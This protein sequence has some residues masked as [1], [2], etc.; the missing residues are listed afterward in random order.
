MAFISIDNVKILGIASAV[1]KTVKVNTNDKLINTTGVA[2]R[3]IVDGI[4]TSDLC[5]VSANKLI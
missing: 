4:N 2:Q 1:P 3:R 5:L